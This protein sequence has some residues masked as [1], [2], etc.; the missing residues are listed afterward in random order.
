MET[1]PAFQRTVLEVVENQLREGDPPETAQTL[2]R[3]VAE[4]YSRREAKKLIGAVLAIETNEMLKENRRFER[5]GFVEALAQLP[6]LR[7][8]EHDES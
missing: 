3:L 6:D 8:D 2:R 1:N 4:G 7:L 5:A